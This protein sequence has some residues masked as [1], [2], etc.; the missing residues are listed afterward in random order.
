M[1]AALEGVVPLTMDEYRCLK[2]FS[3]LY[4]GGLDS[5]AVALL[6]G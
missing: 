5:C 4:S 1:L 2:S 3:V 6:M